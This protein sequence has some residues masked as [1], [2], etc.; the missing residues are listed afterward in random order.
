MCFDLRPKIPSNLNSGAWKT[1]PNLPHGLTSQRDDRDSPFSSLLSKSHIEGQKIPGPVTDRLRGPNGAASVY[2]L[3]GDYNNPILK[4]QA[5]EIVKRHGEIELSG[6]HAPNP[7]TQC[8][9]DDDS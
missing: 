5:A 1:G 2:G 9:R 3:V 8:R 7:R 4:P 6:A